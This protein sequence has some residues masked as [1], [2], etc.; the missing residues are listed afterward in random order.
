VNE[1]LRYDRS[2]LRYDKSITS[3]FLLGCSLLGVFFTL[4]GGSLVG[5]FLGFG[6]GFCFEGGLLLLEDFFVLLHGFGVHLDGGVAEAAVVA[7]PVLT[8]E[9]AGSAGGTGLSG[10][11]DVALA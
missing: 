5:G 10:L 9:D 4:T 8:H 6:F 7:V 3:S 1:V 2:A 11:S